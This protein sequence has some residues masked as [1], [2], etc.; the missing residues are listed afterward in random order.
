MLALAAG[1]AACGDDGDG[2]VLSS[3]GDKEAFCRLASSDEM[4]AFDD[5]EDF[6]PTQA[7]DMAQLDRALD[8]LTDSAPPEIEDDVR[9]VAEGLRE[10]VEVLSDIDMDDPDALA[11]LS[12]RAEE[13]EGMQA[14]MERATEN[15]DRYLEEECGIDPNA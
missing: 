2:G 5:L 11:E 14:E 9:V 7:D 12:E 1:L 8:Q 3:S 13:L 6:D 15:V 4:E 10:L